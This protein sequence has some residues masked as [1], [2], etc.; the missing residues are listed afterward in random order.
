M[1]ELKGKKCYG[2]DKIPQ[3]VLKDSFSSFPA[4]LTSLFNDFARSGM[5]KELK[6]ARILPL[7]KKGSKMD[8]NNYR[9]ISNLSPFSKFYERCLLQRLNTEIPTGD[10]LHQ[11]GFKKFHSTETAL[12]MLQ[13]NIAEKLELKTPSLLYSVDLSAAFDNFLQLI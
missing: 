3:V 5:P 12:L 2:V 11:H 8:I 9:P 6:E 7:H 13:S 1:R 4:T 10:G